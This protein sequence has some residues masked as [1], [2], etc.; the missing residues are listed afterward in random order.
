[1]TFLDTDII[2]ILEID[3]PERFGGGV[4]DYQIVEEEDEMGNPRLDLVIHPRLGAIDPEAATV[5][6]LERI[7]RG[8]GAESVMGRVWKEARVVRILRKPPI[9]GPT[10]KIL[11]LKTSPKT[12]VPPAG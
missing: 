5:F 11:H 4:T 1:M 3:L 7:G 10:G 9:P 12:N 8:S 2:R 6:F